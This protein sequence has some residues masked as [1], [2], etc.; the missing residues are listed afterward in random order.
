MYINSQAVV[1]ITSSRIF[2]NH[3]QGQGS[4]IYNLGTL[5]LTDSRVYNNTQPDSGKLDNIFNGA[6][7]TYVLPAPLG[8]HLDGVFE[9]VP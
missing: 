8:Y 5:Y 4:G 1:N 6:N 3:A 2:A 7:M 9:C